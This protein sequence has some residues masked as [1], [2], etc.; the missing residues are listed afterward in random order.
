MEEE[1]AGN[2]QENYVKLT[3]N[4]NVNKSVTEAN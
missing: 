4:I 2:S 1:K 3:M